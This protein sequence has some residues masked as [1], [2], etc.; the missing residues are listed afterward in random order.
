MLEYH[1]MAVKWH[2][3]DCGPLSYPIISY[4]TTTITAT[5]TLAVPRPCVTRRGRGAVL[6]VDLSSPRV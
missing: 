6:T 5:V 1:L 2:L 3:I 4:V